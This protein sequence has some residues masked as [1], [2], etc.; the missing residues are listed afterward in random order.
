M[1]APDS[2][3]T[4]VLIFVAAIVG[5]LIGSLASLGVT[6]VQTKHDAKI[7]RDEITQRDRELD[8]RFDIARWR[9]RRRLRERTYVGIA[10]AIVD[11]NTQIRKS[12][13]DVK[14]GNSTRIDM[15]GP[16]KEAIA[17]AWVEMTVY[18]SDDA[19]KAWSLWLN[20]SVDVAKAGGNVFIAMTKESP[21]QAEVAT[22]VATLETQAR[23]FSDSCDALLT[24]LRHELDA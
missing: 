9:R 14:K 18:G 12:V 7:R 6:L 3:D 13:E 20:L 10:T 19:V 21:N 16:N 17:K 5:A 4:D 22:L 24:L 15:E 11:I 8:Q 2:S 1:K 23:A